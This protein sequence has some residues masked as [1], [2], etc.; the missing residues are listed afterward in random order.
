MTDFVGNAVSSLSFTRRGVA[1]LLGVCLLLV[2]AWAVPAAEAQTR[3]FTLTADQTD[4]AADDEPVD[5]WDSDVINLAV[6][7]SGTLLMHTQGASLESTAGDEDVCSTTRSLSNSW[8]PN[9]SGWKSVPVHPGDYTVKIVP[10]SGATHV[11]HRI[12][13]RL[14]TSCDSAD[15]HGDS[16]LCATEL[17]SA[18][19][20]NGEI[21][22]LTAGE[23]AD[24]FTFVVSSSTS[25]TIESTGSTDVA[26]ELFDENGDRLAEDDDGGSGTNFKMVETLSAGR[27]YVRVYGFNGALGTYSVSYQ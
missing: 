1:A 20:K 23:D 14:L 8:L 21:E 22:T 11:K 16:A 7:Q 2:G 15:D 25:V 13:F 19:S 3:N 9:F 10:P 18:V 24:F 17:C 5:E 26:A 12:R 4:E 27:Y 6:D